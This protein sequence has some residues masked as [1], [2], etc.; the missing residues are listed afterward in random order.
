MGFPGDISMPADLGSF[1]PPLAS[2]SPHDMTGPHVNT[3]TTGPMY[4][5]QHPMQAGT[6]G[7]M[8]RLGLGMFHSDD[9]L[10]YP[11]QPRDFNFPH[12]SSSMNQNST[13]SSQQQQSDMN[14]FQ[15]NNNFIEAELM[16]PLPPYLMQNHSQVFDFP[17]QM[18]SDPM[19]VPMQPSRPPPPAPPPQRITSLQQ[20]QLAAHQRQHEST[21][22]S[23]AN[24]P[25]SGIFPH[26]D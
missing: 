7:D 15:P 4:H 25:W 11:N 10:A 20:R 23:F 17:S 8:G 21:L 22:E 19:F 13:M 12:T 14:F 24:T 16:G 5:Q 18:Y 26:L 9:P 1:S 6:V 2:M 3:M